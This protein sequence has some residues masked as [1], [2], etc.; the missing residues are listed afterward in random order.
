MKLSNQIQSYL[1]ELSERLHKTEKEA[2]ELAIF[3]FY[4]DK[5]KFIFSPHSKDMWFKDEIPIIDDVVEMEDW[6]GNEFK[7]IQFPGT[8]KSRELMGRRIKELRED[9]KMTQEELAEKAGILRP[10]LTRIEAGKYSTG[11]DILS[12]IA[13]ALGKRLDII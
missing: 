13:N 3:E 7:W 8:Q 1:S 12:K 2:I 5:H 9:A 10:N 4:H 11:Q 6:E